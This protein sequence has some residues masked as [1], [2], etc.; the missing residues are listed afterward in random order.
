MR[1]LDLN[2]RGQLTEEAKTGKAL[3]KAL[4]IVN[5]SAQ[6]FAHWALRDDGDTRQG[7]LAIERAVLWSWHRIQ[8]VDEDSNKNAATKAFKI[9]WQH[10]N[11]FS[12]HY[13]ERIRPHCYRENGLTRYASNG[14]ESSLVVFEQIGILASLG[15]FSLHQALSPHPSENAK[16]NWQIKTNEV[17]EALASILVNNGVSNTPCLDRHCQDITLAMLALLGTGHRNIAEEWLQKLFRNVDYAY[18][19]KKYVP[20]ATDSLDDLVEEGGWLGEQATDRM[21]EM[22][23]MLASIASFSVIMGMD[24]LYEQLA[25]NARDKYP[26]VCIQ[27]W[28][29][30]KDL[31][32][33]LYFKPAQFESGVTEAPIY[34][35][36]TAAEYREQIDMICDSE[37]KKVVSDSPAAKAGLWVLDLIAHRHFST[38]VSPVFW[39]SLMGQGS[40]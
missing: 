30:E 36:S 23:W 29:P 31:Y 8:L 33:Y 6:M 35:P 28:H 15:L 19:K 16:N 40:R 17:T 3:L 9:M 39:Y 13:F 5:L 7:L 4:Q 21:M 27:L 24:V 22:S 11:R 32:Q 12:L 25:K 2:D 20:I 26:K 38:P 10:Y 1:T 14:I 37:F 18:R 34:F